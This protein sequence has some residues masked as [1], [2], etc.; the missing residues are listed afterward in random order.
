MEKNLDMLFRENCSSTHRIFMN[1]AWGTIEL[2]RQWLV[3]PRCSASQGSARW[4]KD[5]DVEFDSDRRQRRVSCR[6]AGWLH[7]EA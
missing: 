5:G 1:E 6:E 7:G 4:R 2:E 3:V